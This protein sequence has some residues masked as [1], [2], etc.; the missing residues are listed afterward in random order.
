MLD[1]VLEAGEVLFLPAGWW[2]QVRSLDMSITVTFMN[3]VFPNR[4][5]WVHPD[6]REELSRA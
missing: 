5:D 4:F 6:L 1:V 2:H 3:F